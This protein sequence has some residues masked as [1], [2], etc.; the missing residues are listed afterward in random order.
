MS[1]VLLALSLV[2]LLSGPLLYALARSRAGLLA[3]LDGF[4]FVSI[5]GLVLIEVV[6]GT[7]GAGGTWS[8]LF[9]AIGLLGPSLLERWISRARREAHLAALLLAMVGLVI[10]SFGDGVA[11]SSGGDAH[12]PLALPL[13]VAVHRL[14]VGL[15]IWW[16]LYPVF[17]RWPPMLA[18]LAMCAGTL[19]GYLT[20]PTLGTL[21]GADGW[22]WF[23]A[24]VAGTILHVVFGRPHIDPHVQHPHAPRLEGIGNL[25]ALVGLVML[26]R[27]DEDALPAATLFAH[28]AQI[29]AAAA[30]WLLA[31]YLAGVLLLLRGGWRAAVQQV[32][33]RW[34]DVSAIWIVLAILAVA[35]LS[36]HIDGFTPS[37]PDAPHLLALL[38]LAALY[39]SSLL[40]SGGRAWIA[41]A[42]PRR[43]HAHQHAH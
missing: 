1:L 42:L 10:H 37:P 6:P 27:L 38:A 3:F 34:V 12:V 43:G 9:V 20:G 40:R 26:S 41:T 35:L 36:A 4:L 19:G 7:F 30:P 39:A 22:A 13:A 29:G 16:L 8:L 28:F 2:A 17:G 25:V 15:M 31:V 21:L 5:F 14:P 18:L 23:Q 32:A 11:L 33:V 24:L